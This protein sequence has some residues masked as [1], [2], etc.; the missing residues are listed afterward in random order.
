LNLILVLGFV[1]N[2]RLVLGLVFFKN[3]I[4]IPIVSLCRSGK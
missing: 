1:E 4:D 2:L 3:R